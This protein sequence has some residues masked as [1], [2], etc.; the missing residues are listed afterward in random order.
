MELPQF[1][2]PRLTQGIPQHAKLKNIVA[3]ICRTDRG[4]NGASYPNLPFTR[5]RVKVVYRFSVQKSSQN[6]SSRFQ[7]LTR[8]VIKI[9]HFNFDHFSSQSCKFDHFHNFRELLMCVSF[10]KYTNLRFGLR[11]AQDLGFNSWRARRV[12]AATCV[13]RNISYDRIPL[14]F[15]SI[16]RLYTTTRAGINLT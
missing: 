7:T 10:R 6:S 8:K 9:E 13:Y 4:A 3:R 15:N 2:D 5:F 14:G 11:I 16:R 12:R 1:L